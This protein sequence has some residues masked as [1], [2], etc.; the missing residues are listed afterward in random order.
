MAVQ[1]RSGVSHSDSRTIAAAARIAKMYYTVFKIRAIEIA[2]NR[3]C[4]DVARERFIIQLRTMFPL[5]WK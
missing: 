3:G 5:S 4:S 2:R 1:N